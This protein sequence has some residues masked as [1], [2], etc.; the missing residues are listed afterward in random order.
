MRLSMI[1]AMGK[2][3]V[4][5]INN[6]LPWKLSADLQYF[7]KVTMG[8]PIIMGRKTFESI[9]KPLPGRTNIVI[10]R[11]KTWQAEG[12]QVAHSIEAAKK[13]A[14]EEKAKEAMVIGGAE[15]YALALP[16]A[17]KLYVTEVDLSPEGDAYFPEISKSW[18]KVRN[19]K[20]K[21]E[22]GNPAYNF[23]VYER[24][25]AAHFLLLAIIFMALAQVF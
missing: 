19:K 21:A 12:V 2:N 7:K 17:E 9:G 15:I 23:V 8:K 24:L 13:I 25:T 5:G 6:Q 16:E 4:I 3:R 20:H 14:K 22:G 18:L 10:T 11:S 1:V